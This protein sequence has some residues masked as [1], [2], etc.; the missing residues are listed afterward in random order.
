MI[1][2]ARLRSP[3]TLAFLL[4]RSLGAV[5]ALW[6]AVTIVFIMVHVTGSPAEVLAP[7]NATDEQIAL[8]AAQY[9]FDQPLPVQYGRFLWSV[10]TGD[11][12]P[13][14]YTGRPAFVE[15]LR[16]VPNTLALSLSAVVIG[17]ALGL[18]VGYLSALSPHGLVRVLPLRI[19]MTLQAIPSFFLA[20][21]LVLLFSLTLHWL[22]TSGSGGWRH[23]ILPVAVLSSMVAPNVARL[24]R[25]TIREMAHEDHI[26]TARAKG[27][28]EAAVRRRHLAI[29]AMGPVIALI[30]LQAG[31][32]LA[33]A[34]VTET[35][36]S[37]PGVG[38]LLVRSVTLRDYPVALAAVLL[39][40]FGFVI[41]SL[42]VDLCAVLIDP[43]VQK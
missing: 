15:V 14:L 24:F 41:A 33:G 17:S 2:R 30:G 43:R 23:L 32:V 11:F 9:G 27:L 6:G 36:F 25:S 42:I 38:E 29:N 34:V 13:S 35:V 12:P 16:R 18:W 1:W 40:C 10:V 28:P 31:G 5:L 39:V 19:L 3:L 20:L 37:Y 8:L 21:L 4:R 26:L 7:E 22:P